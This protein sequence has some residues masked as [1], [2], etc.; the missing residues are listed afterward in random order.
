MPSHVYTN[1]IVLSSYQTFLEQKKKQSVIFTYGKKSYTL[2]SKPIIFSSFKF[3]LSLSHFHY[4]PIIS[5]AQYWQ[6]YEEVCLGH[7]TT[8]L[9]SPH[10]RGT[11]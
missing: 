7:T 5:G 3:P 2:S 11:D 1:I 6:T 8:D 10:I 4:K 9:H